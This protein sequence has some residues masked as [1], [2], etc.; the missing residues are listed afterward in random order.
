MKY[1]LIVT[2]TLCL[3][4]FACKKDKTAPL[5][6]PV[7]NLCDSINPVSFINDIDPILNT[8]NC[9]ACHSSIAPMFSDYSSVFDARDP[10]LKSIQHN[11]AFRPMPE[12]G[13]KLPDSLINLV[14]C[15]IESGAPNN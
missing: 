1:I 13:A 5:V 14:H 15:W 11:P 10:I 7:V 3:F 8:N 2:Y 6:P 12:N 9:Y 4:C